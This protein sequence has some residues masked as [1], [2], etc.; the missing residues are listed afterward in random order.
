GGH[1]GGATPVPIPNTEVKP[2]SADGTR[3]GTAWES[4]SLPEVDL[5]SL[6]V[7]WGFLISSTRPKQTRCAVVPIAS[8]ASITL[9]PLQEYPCGNN[10]ARSGRCVNSVLRACIGS[11]SAARF[12]G[13][14]PKLTP[15]PM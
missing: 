8:I 11:S 12:A 14:L 10:L 5:E 2:S 3:L 7:R 9:P 4:R 15:T 1:S 6:T 13:T